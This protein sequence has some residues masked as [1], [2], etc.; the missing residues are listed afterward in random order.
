[1]GA[2]PEIRILHVG[3]NVPVIA[4]ISTPSHRAPM[5]VPV[6]LRDGDVVEGILDAVA[7]MQANLIGMATV[8]H[9][10]PLDA[11][12]GSTTER[13]LRQAPCPVL[14]VPAGGR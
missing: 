5:H 14:A 13:V 12:R 11:L 8:G 10:G 4:T 9:R 1:L 6:E 2:A 3:K 7:E